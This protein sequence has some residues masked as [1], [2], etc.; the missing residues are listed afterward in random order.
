M[1]HHTHCGPHKLSFLL[2]V[3][4]AL[5]WGVVGFFS[6]NFIDA[7]LGAGSV[8]SRVVYALVGLA[9]LMMLI[10]GK[11]KFCLRAEKKAMGMGMENKGMMMMGVDKKM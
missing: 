8:A 1:M 11:C 5:N 7:I 2:V 6:Y 4:G 10:V 9:G 3:I